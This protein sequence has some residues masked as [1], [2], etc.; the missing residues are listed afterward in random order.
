MIDFTQHSL[1]DGTDGR[2]STGPLANDYFIWQ[3]IQVK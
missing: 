1:T 2:L 3:T